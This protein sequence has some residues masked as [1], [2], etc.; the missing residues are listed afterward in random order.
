MNPDP[1]AFEAIVSA[2]HDRLLAV[3]LEKT[4]IKPAPDKWSSKEILGHLIDSASNNH[5][6]F[7]R[8]QEQ[9]SLSLPGCNQENWV[10]IQ[11]YHAMSWD[12]LVPLWHLLSTLLLHI[13]KGMPEDC[14][15]NI[16][17]SPEGPITLAGLVKDYFRHLE[18]HVQHFENNQEN[19]S[20]GFT[21]KAWWNT[22]APCGLSSPNDRARKNSCGTPSRINCRVFLKPNRS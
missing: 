20:P 5:Q 17:H 14:L 9:G 4:S 18:G 22:T 3:P 11:R 16:Y 2:F 6:R 13:I 19:L 1:E 12:D 15:G 7:V 8:L 21:E 10:R